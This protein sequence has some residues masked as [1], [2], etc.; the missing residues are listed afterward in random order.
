MRPYTQYI[1]IDFSVFISSIVFFKGN[2]L[3][4]GADKALI[5]SRNIALAFTEIWDF[6]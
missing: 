1:L 5:L 3:V 6:L 2:W 4:K